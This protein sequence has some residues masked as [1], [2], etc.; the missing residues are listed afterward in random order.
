[1]RGA[2]LLVTVALLA[3]AGLASAAP[4]KVGWMVYPYHIPA[5]DED[6]QRLLTWPDV[7][8]IGLQ[9]TASASYAPSLQQQRAAELHRAGKK[10]IVDLWFGSTEPFSWRRFNFPNVALDPQIRQE[11]FTKCVDPWLKYWGAENLY[12]VHL[13]EETGMQFGWDADVPGYP[14]DQL[15]YGNSNSYDNPSSFLWSRGVSGPYVLS[16]RKFA[17]RLQQDTGLDV[18]LAA[19]WNSAENTR[20]NTW[21]QQNMEAGAHIQFARYLHQK[22]P[23]LRV[24]AFNTGVALLPQ[25]EVLDGQFIDPYI[26]TTSVYTGLRH[27]RKLM[28]PEADLVA[29]MWGNRDKPLSQRMPQQA[30]C[31]LAGADILSTYGDKE[32]ESDEWMKVV[33]DSVKPFVGLPRF[34]ARPEV[35]YLGGGV[36]GSAVLT[37]GDWWITGFASYDVADPWMT[38][39]V[40]S[41]LDKL[42]QYKLIFGWNHTRPEVEAWVRQGG[43]LVGVYSGGELLERAGLIES[44]RKT[45]RFEGEYKPDDW[46]RQ[47]LRLRESYQL[48]LQ[49][50]AEYTV[51]APQTVHQDQFLYVAPY[52]QGLIVFL[53][54]IQYVHPPWQYEPGWE[55]YRQLL[56]DLCRGALLYRGQGA[57]ADT[58][59]DDPALGNDYMRVTSADGKLTVYVLLNDAHGPNQSPT[60]F[61]VPGRDRVTGQTDVTF[62]E[63]HPVVMIEKGGN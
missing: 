13:M 26:G 54:A 56:T 58:C 24:Y 20:F 45:G 38:S 1:M 61:V 21:V 46:V 36:F 48:D 15:G 35:L 55:V 18:R 41:P 33:H 19:V 14:G 29:M 16:I 51:K 4:E 43:I 44:T 11:F 34:Q 27:F 8:Y 22:H 32:C 9:W 47:N 42:G 57:T 25:S 12:A 40:Q 49:P 6:Y 5:K 10:L 31:F 28:R 30:A 37:A 23:G 2:V 62:G 52:G 7:E 17:D 3:C 60:S 39:G 63:E 59:F 50:V 53:P